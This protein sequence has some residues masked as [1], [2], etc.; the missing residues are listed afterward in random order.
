M[1][2]APKGTPES[3]PG[4]EPDPEHAAALENMEREARE[5]IIKTPDDRLGLP[6]E[7][8]VSST[9]TSDALIEAKQAEKEPYSLPPEA[10][11]PKTIIPGPNGPQAV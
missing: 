9:P 8:A 7:I 3:A 4:M 6:R 1:A 11:G 5:S 2:N 10:Q